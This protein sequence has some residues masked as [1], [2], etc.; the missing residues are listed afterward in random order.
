MSK[1][2][3]DPEPPEARFQREDVLYDV[4]ERHPGAKGVLLSFG[5]PCFDCVVAETETVA[6]GCAPLLLNVDAVLAK[7]NALP[8]D[9]AEKPRSA[10]LGKFQR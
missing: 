2:K 6:E 10:A 8:P 9:P 5:L 4:V 3:A 7:L 1:K